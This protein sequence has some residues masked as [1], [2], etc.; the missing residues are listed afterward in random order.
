MKSKNLIF[1][2]ILILSF[3]VSSYSQSESYEYGELIYSSF[4]GHAKKV[5]VTITLN[6]ELSQS[7]TIKLEKGDISVNAIPAFIELKSLSQKGWDVYNTNVA[8]AANSRITRIYQL[9]RKIE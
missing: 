3:S 6:D 9:R 8:V 5:I 1:S 4:V 7:E 2:L